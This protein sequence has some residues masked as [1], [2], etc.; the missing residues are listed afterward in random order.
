MGLEINTQAAAGA[1]R[2]SPIQG[3]NFLAAKSGIKVFTVGSDAHSLD[4]LGYYLEEALDLLDEFGLV[5]H[6]FLQASRSLL[7]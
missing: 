1:E 7:V 3:N 5:N 6:V 2:I 4:E